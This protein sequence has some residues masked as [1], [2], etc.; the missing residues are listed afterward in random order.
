ME[1]SLKD[2][3]ALVVLMKCQTTDILMAQKL[4]HGKT[5]ENRKS[6]HLHESEIDKS[7]FEHEVALKLFNQ[8]T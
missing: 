5:K 6:R 8:L 7:N 3:S 1:E 2:D 4:F